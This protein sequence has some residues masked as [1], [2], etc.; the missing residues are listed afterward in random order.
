MPPVKT[1]SS[2]SAAS[3]SARNALENREDFSLWAEAVKQQ[4]LEALQKRQRSN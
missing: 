2:V 4:M 1:S 3:S